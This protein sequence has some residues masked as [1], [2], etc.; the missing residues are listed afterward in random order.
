VNL[1]KTEE[2]LFSRY[3][4]L[5]ERRDLS[6]ERQIWTSGTDV[7]SNCQGRFTWCNGGTNAAINALTR[8]N[9]DQTVQASVDHCM[10]MQVKTVG[11]EMILTLSAQP[12]ISPLP[13]ICEVSFKK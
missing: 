8:L 11:N 7:G 13:V 2:N 1:I 3:V 9:Y 10:T 6:Q 5:I 12:C 4:V